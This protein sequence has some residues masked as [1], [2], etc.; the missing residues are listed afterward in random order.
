MSHT[1]L[2]R[3]RKQKWVGGGAKEELLFHPGLS[4]ALKGTPMLQQS[5]PVRH[6]SFYFPPPKK[7]TK[8]YP[9]KNK[10]WCISFSFLPPY[11]FQVVCILDL[12]QVQG[13]FTW[14]RKA[15]SHPTS[16]GV[17]RSIQPIL[18]LMP[19]HVRIKKKK[20]GGGGGEI[21]NENFETKS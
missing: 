16:V 18:L 11:H 9:L 13:F 6:F 20:G 17:S 4:R 3:K 12:F 1:L 19:Q 15:A 21:K 7:K 14:K 10:W 2:M 8:Y 5:A